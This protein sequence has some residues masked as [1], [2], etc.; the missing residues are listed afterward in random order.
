MCLSFTLGLWSILL[1]VAFCFGKKLAF[2]YLGKL[3]QMIYVLCVILL[4]LNFCPNKRNKYYKAG[5]K[6]QIC[7]TSVTSLHKICLDKLSGGL[8]S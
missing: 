8:L 5:Q 6:F 2:T 3:L 1:L 4:I 7:Y